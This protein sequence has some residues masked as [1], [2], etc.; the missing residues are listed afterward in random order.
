MG[1]LKPNWASRR[2]LIVLALVVLVGGGLAAFMPPPGHP[3]AGEEKA[4]ADAGLN[5]LTVE[6]VAGM[7][8]TLSVPADVRKGLRIKGSHLVE[9]PR[10]TRQVIM[11]G[12]TALDYNKIGRV[13]TRFNAEVIEIRQVRDSQRSPSG[14]TQFR[15]V[16]TGDMVKKGEMLAVVWSTDVG[17]R[18]ND[19][20]EGLVQFWLDE[21]RLKL[22]TKLYQ[23]GSIPLDTLNQTRR[24]VLTD[25]SAVSRAER[26]LRT[27]NIPER[28]I[29]AVRQEAR[30]AHEKS[31]F[32]PDPEKERLW[33]RSELLAPRD[34]TLVERN[35]TRGEFVADNTVNLFT[36]A[37]VDTL[38][39]TANLPEDFL[40]EL[41]RLPRDQWRWKVKLEGVAPIEG[42]IDEVSRIVDPNQHTALV[43]GYIDNPKR[44]LLAGQ[45]VS[46]T[47]E[48]PP[49]TDVVEVPLTALAEDG[50][51]SFVFVQSE[52]DKHIY[53]LRR[54]KVTHRFEKT[55]YV[56]S[57]LAPGE[58]V[59]SSE[60]AAKGLL[61]LKELHVGERVLGSGVLELRNALDNITP[62]AQGG[63]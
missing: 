10:Q 53:T 54:V 34:G 1:F 55:A 44:H 8:Y 32:K 50:Q 49:P 45:Y 27:W 62:L 13:R 12:S 26:T 36:V 59:L 58:D 37:D 22:R 23:E 60:Q 2:W 39:V 33:P 20:F 6:P 48:L 56:R 42:P 43:K 18:K 28:E 11:P 47:V 51:Q 61:P 9:K 4:P 24:D 15:E 35:V 57:R 25:Q 29:E 63:H 16:R 46:A 52:P 38:L 30:L 3:H 17:S 21:Q 14:E 41:W 31:R 5:L 7:P 19:L 40:P